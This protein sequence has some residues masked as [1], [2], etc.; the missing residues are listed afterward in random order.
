MSVACV[1][2]NFSKERELGSFRMKGNNFA[3]GKNYE[4]LIQIYTV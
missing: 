3:V 1:A 4:S 2:G